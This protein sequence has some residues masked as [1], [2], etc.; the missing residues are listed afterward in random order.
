ME[1]IKK[2]TRRAWNGGPKVK[3]SSYDDDMVDMDDVN[4]SLEDLDGMEDGDVSSI[5]GDLGLGMYDESGDFGNLEKYDTYERTSEGTMTDEEIKI[6]ALK[7]ATNMAKLFTNVSVGD[8][9]S[10]A[11]T[12]A[13]YFK[14]YEVGKK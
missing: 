14:H 11:V 4:Y 6:E 2:K 10:M 13:R 7:Q 5:L 9:L 12:L 1:P 8:V 3:M